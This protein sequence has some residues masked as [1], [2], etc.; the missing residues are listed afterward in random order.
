MV[1]ATTLRAIASWRRGTYAAL[2]ALDRSAPF[3]AAGRRGGN[4]TNPIA[5]NHSE[6]HTDA[7]ADNH[8]HL[9]AY[10]D[11][12]A[13]ADAHAVRRRVPATLC[14]GRHAEASADA[15]RRRGRENRLPMRLRTLPRLPARHRARL[16]DH[17]RMRLSLRGA[18]RNPG[19]HSTADADGD[20]RSLP[21][22]LQP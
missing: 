3:H 22:R 17:A 9:H 21:G 1:G 20:A 4:D 8:P 18:D 6:L 14:R 13:N 16:P 5:H 12:D 10:T 15:V 7:D 19:S 11:R 2:P